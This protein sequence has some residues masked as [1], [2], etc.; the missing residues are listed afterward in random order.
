MADSSLCVRRD[1]KLVLAVAIVCSVVGYGGYL[2]GL[3]EAWA[4]SPGTVGFYFIWSVLS[5]VSA[6]WVIIVVYAS[7]R[8]LDSRNKWLEYGLDAVMPFY[9]FHHPA[10][11]AIA[12]FVVYHTMAIV[13]MRRVRSMTSETSGGYM[14]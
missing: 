3:A 6:C 5:A 1:W 11:I 2:A 12:F 8:L 4:Y 14:S 7:M 9:V 13:C 10:I